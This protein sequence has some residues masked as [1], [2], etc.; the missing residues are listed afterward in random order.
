MSALSI[1]LAFLG[2]GRRCWLPKTGVDGATWGHLS[3]SPALS[4][5]PFPDLFLP[6]LWDSPGRGTWLWEWEELVRVGWTEDQVLVRSGLSAPPSAPVAPAALPANFLSSRQAMVGL[7]GVSGAGDGGVDG[8]SYG[9]GAQK[10]WRLCRG[11]CFFCLERHLV[12]GRV[13]T[14]TPG[15]ARLKS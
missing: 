15:R 12:A 3:P 9:E 13:R 8:T 10:P 1:L 5:G 14:L 4:P 7:G 2:V 6:T 11:G